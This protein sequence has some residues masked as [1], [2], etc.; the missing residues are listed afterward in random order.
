MQPFLEKAWNAIKDAAP[1]NWKQVLFGL[2]MLATTFVAT[3]CGVLPPDAPLPPIPDPI[4]EPGNMGW[5][6]DDDAVKEVR[7]T[8]EFKTFGATPAGKSDDP[9]PKVVYLWQNYQKLFNAPR[10]SKNQSSIGSCVSF[11]TNQAVETTLATQIVFLRGSK[12]EFKHISEEV[13]YGG[14]RVQVG[15]GRIR[16][17]GSVGS[18]GAEFVQKWG[19]VERAKHGQYDLSAY[20]VSTCRTFGDR[21]VPVDLQAIAKERPVKDI[22]FCKSWAEVKRA[23]ASGYALSICSDQGFEGNRDANGVKKPRGSWAHCMAIDGYHTEGA[24]EYAHID[25][26]WGARPSEGPT[27]WGNPPDSGFW[28]ESSV[29]DRLAKMQG[30]EVIAFSAVRGWPSRKLD[31][32][33][34]VEPRP[35]PGLRFAQREVLY[36]SI[37]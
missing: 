26:S 27:G 1:K 21:G 24:T 25:N 16:G 4:F 10:P 37:P 31:W 29:I 15:K 2:F 14:S 30:N 20:S 22:T 23:L 17:D 33:V 19:I 35:D 3:R 13:T 9:L 7:D 5:V 18:W 34:H 32:F 12:D 8:L 6:R 36:A 11:G 28:V